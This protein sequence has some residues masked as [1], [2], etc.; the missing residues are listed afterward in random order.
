MN[1]NTTILNKLIKS[2][3][4]CNPDSKTN[5]SFAL[6]FV[7]VALK[8]FQIYNYKTCRRTDNGITGHVMREMLR[9]TKYLL[10][11]GAIVTTTLTSDKYRQSPLYQC[12]L[13]IP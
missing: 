5:F 4:K 7:N 2:S 1:S 9:P 11:R 13:E 6:I 12:G 3:A 8:K 10:D